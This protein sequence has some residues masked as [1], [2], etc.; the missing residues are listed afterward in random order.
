M[1]SML[2]AEQDYT[3]SSIYSKELRALIAEC[4][5]LA[6]AN[7]IPA[8]EL[9]QRTADGVSAAQMSMGTILGTPLTEWAEPVLSAQWYS[10]QD[11]ADSEQAR[12][13]A[14]FKKL[15]VQVEEQKNQRLRQVATQMAAAP[16]QQNGEQGQAGPPTPVQTAQ[17]AK[18]ASLAPISRL[19]VI[20]QTK[21]KFGLIGGGHKAFRLENLTPEMTV[22]QVKDML[23]RMG[24]GIKA[25]GMNM[26]HGRTLMLNHQRLAEF[27]GIDVVRAMDA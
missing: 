15:Q 23:E 7:R 19:R 11:E 9:V 24:C 8:A 20:V 13:A 10:G 12:L 1:G 22:V 18:S 3:G 4:L 5:L 17:P 14:E 25:T 21:P 2:D 26:M 27:P 16:A 6:P